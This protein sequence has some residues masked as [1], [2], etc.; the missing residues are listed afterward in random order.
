MDITATRDVKLMPDVEKRSLESLLG[1]SLAP[2]QHVLILTYTPSVLPTD[3]ARETA[4]RRIA[5]TLAVNQEFAGSQ[6]V[7]AEEADAAIDEALTQ[8]RRRS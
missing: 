8:V 1:A 3:E 6:G 7:S 5:L 4:R 2:E